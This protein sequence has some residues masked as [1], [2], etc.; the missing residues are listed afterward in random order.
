MKTKEKEARTSITS[1]FGLPF[2]NIASEIHEIAKIKQL[3]RSKLSRESFENIEIVF[4]C[5]G[6]IFGLSDG[7]QIEH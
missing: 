6:N 1:S 4:R 3:N 2:Q 5:P 7:Y